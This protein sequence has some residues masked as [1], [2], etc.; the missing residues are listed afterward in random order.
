MIKKISIDLL[1][2]RIKS[3]PANIVLYGAGTLGQLTQFALAKHDLKADYFCD[4]DEVKQGKENHGVFVISSNELIK[5]G[6]DSHIF[7]CNNYPDSI[8]QLE[9]LGLKN[10]YSCVELLESTDFSL[11]RLDSSL[12]RL[13]TQLIKIEREIAI[14]KTSWIKNT[15]SSKLD[16]KYL[17]VVV[18]EIC[19]LKCKDCS[20]LMQYYK[21]PQHSDLDILLSSL[22]RI[23]KC[24]DHLCEF[25][26]LGGEPLVN[27]D[28]YKVI[29]KLTSFENV[30]KVIIYTNATIVPKGGDLEC[31]KHEKII[32]DISNYGSDSRKH[33]LLID[34]LKANNIAFQTRI[35]DVWTD[36]GEIRYRE[37]TETEL[38]N[39][40]N[41]CCV[42]DNMSLMHGNLYRCPFSANG[43]V[44]KAIP[45]KSSDVVD[46]ADENICLDELKGH[47]FDLYN[48]RKYITPCT[49][50][51]GRD[52]STPLIKAA[53]QIKKPLQFEVVD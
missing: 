22:T 7:V 17:D 29:E 53:I 35:V 11:V 43:A 34:T 25:R 49:Y 50:C 15:V 1:F 27:K 21:K 18:T 19:S 16:M 23:M 46:V 13:D 9:K 51:N 48:N 32:F 20:N 39:K 40:F 10:I 36:S 31:L 41:N 42:K 12:A 3:N 6:R 30:D 33:D 47:I 4:N 2:D 44:L 52:L 45:H 8:E 38:F 5:L 26:V 37:E 14:Y 28:V 24:V